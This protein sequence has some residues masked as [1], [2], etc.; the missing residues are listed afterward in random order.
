MLFKKRTLFK[1]AIAV[2]VFLVLA[3]SPLAAFAQTQPIRT[4]PT[5]QKVV[6][7]TFDGTFSSG[8]TDQIISTLRSEG[9]TAT[10]F[11]A[12]TF[13]DN[14]P[15]HTRRIR[16]NCF[17]LGNHSNTH[18]DFVNLTDN[19]IISEI[20]IA[21][22]KLIDT[23]AGETKP[24]FRLPYGSYNSRVLAAV[25]RTG[26][27][28]IIQWNIDTIDWREDTTA[29]QIVQRVRNGLRP[30]SIILMHVAGPQTAA[31]LPE[32]IRHIKS[33]GYTFT[34]L[35]RFYGVPQAQQHVPGLRDVLCFNWYFEPIR[36]L[37]AE[38]VITG[39]PN[40]TYRPQ[41]T[42]SRAEF[43]KLLVEAENIPLEAATGMFSDVPSTHWAARYIE[44]AVRRGLIS[45]YSDGTFRPSVA[46]QRQDMARAIVLV[47]GL[48][49]NTS[50]TGFSDVPQ[51]SPF[52]Q[53]IM[54]AKNNG[55]L[56][57]YPNGTFK[58]AG[59]LTRA[60][61]AQV[62]FKITR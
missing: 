27:N 45:G 10:F 16:N 28:R 21:R 46:I 55:I 33:Q 47:E 37:K 38:G 32:V 40:G 34:D 7:L 9:A 53:Y 49:I 23:A 60:E 14:F 24:F 20:S 19:Q 25:E 54:T 30:G 4:L 3:F 51:S 59:S 44:T 22:Q 56:T 42:I 31:A 2:F 1:G 62:I 6:A 12:G 41:A 35:P 26:Y 5:S 48:A 61:S 8:S 52:F 13:A 57:G 11:L 43:V 39:Y 50:G 17:A 29:Q 58:P 15:D 18:P 36:V